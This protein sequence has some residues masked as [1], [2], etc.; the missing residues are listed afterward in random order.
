MGNMHFFHKSNKQGKLG[1]A[2]IAALFQGLVGTDGRK[3]DLLLGDAKVEV[4]TDFYA[5]KPGGN[6]FIER[7]SDIA[8]GKPGGPWQA[9]EHGCAYYLYYFMNSDIGYC[10]KLD[11]L[12]GQ[13][14]ALEPSLSPVEVRNVRWTTV[15]YKVPHTS[16]VAD[17]C[18]THKA[19]K[20]SLV[21]GDVALL[22]LF[23]GPGHGE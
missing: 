11:N 3:G 6:F 4:K 20:L 22:E 13:L 5:H 14:H 16:L 15:G 17:F 7:Y 10:F 9:A 12:L 1:E 23:M 19:G 2:R 21:S 8:K 18:F